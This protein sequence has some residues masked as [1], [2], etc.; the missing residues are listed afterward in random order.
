[1]V[2]KKGYIDN[3]WVLQAQEESFPEKERLRNNSRPV[4]SKSRII[5]L[6]IPVLS[7]AIYTKPRLM[8]SGNQ[9]SVAMNK[10]SVRIVSQEYIFIGRVGNYLFQID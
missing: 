7:G 3:Q 8:S 1:M 10:F 9:L 5:C 2:L 4:I 6:I